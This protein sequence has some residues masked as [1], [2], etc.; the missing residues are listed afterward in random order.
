MLIDVSD[1]KKR[2]WNS[3]SFEFYEDLSIKALEYEIEFFKPVKV[4]IDITNCGSYF[5]VN[6]RIV[7]VLKLTCDRCLKTYEYLMNTS[8]IEQ[9][10]Q[11]SNCESSSAHGCKNSLK[12]HEERIPFSGDFIDIDSE[13]LAS[14]RLALPM[15]HLCREDCLG[16]CPKCG[17]DLNFEQCK[18]QKDEI[19]IRMS[20]LKKLLK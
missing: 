7:A 11:K 9:Y 6:G 17:V 18:C 13:V 1:L 2:K 3:R 14:I 8:L 20:V 5:Q 16:I 12:L 10:Y 19:D 15:K 4:S